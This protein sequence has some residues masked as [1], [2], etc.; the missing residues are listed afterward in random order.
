MS[1]EET[2]LVLV[3]TISQFRIRYVVEVPVGVDDY[4]K[5]K[6]LWALDTVSCEEAKEFSQE[7]LGELIVSHRVIDEKEAL[8]LCDE[9]NEY[10]NSWT[11]EHKIKTFVTKWEEQQKQ[12][13]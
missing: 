10:A 11:K 5:D 1:K 2:Q 6:K 8:Q 3:E 4:G 12:V 9:D 7:S 13:V